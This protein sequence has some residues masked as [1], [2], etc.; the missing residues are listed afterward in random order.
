MGENLDLEKINR[1]NQIKKA[2]CIITGICIGALL[3]GIIL[4]GRAMEVDARISEIQTNL[5]KEVFRF[6]VLA[7]SDSDEAQRVKLKVRD[8]VL[9]YMKKNMPGNQ[10]MVSASQTKEWTKEHLREIE[11]V[12]EEVVREEGYLYG[13]KANVTTCYFPEKRYGDVVFPEGYYEALRIELGDAKGHNWWCVLYPNLCFIDATYAVVSEEGKEQLKEALTDEEF[14][15][16]TATTEFKIK[17]FF[18][19]NIFEE[20]E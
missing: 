19:G 11:S 7:D 8:H 14:E 12:S 1:K 6:H 3:T 4:R 17:S 20:K 15:M 10:D 13:V 16:V 2:V 5:S 18:F 9:E